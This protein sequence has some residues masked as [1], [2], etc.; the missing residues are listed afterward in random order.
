MLLKE[1]C[2]YVVQQKLLNMGAEG[3][4]ISI[5]RFCN[6]ELPFNS[7]GMYRGY[8]KNNEVPVIAIYK[9]PL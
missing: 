1:A 5:D 8:R 7:D 2:E 3:G 9:Q 6:I 4:L